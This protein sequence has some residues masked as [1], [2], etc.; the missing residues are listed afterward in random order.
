MSANPTIAIITA[1]LLAILSSLETIANAV[2]YVV[3]LPDSGDI[4]MEKIPCG[5]KS[6][7]GVVTVETNP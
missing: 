4:V 3:K 5:K 7:I 2:V 6:V 1:N